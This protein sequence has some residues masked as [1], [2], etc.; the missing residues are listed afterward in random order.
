MQHPLLLSL[1]SPLPPRKA[2]HP[3]FSLF[4]SLRAPQD[5]GP[6]HQALRQTYIRKVG[7]TLNLLIPFQ[8]IM[9]APR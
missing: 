7:D 3:L 8:V 4:P 1:N 6:D 5:L 9:P 2:H